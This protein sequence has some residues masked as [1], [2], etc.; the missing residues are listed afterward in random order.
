MELCM[1]KDKS[2]E[3]TAAYRERLAEKKA[4][5]AEIADAKATIKRLNLCGFSE[6]AFN[7][8]ARTCAQEIQIHRSWLRALQQ[9]DVFPEETLRQLDKRAWQALLDSD[10]LGVG[11]LGGKWIDG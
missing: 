4:V 2:K 9:P 10:N 7:T 6:I 3:R 11:K 5:A 8:P 1:K